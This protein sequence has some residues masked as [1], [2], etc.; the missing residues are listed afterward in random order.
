VRSISRT[1]AEMVRE[2]FQATRQRRLAVHPRVHRSWTFAGLRAFSNCLLRDLNTAVVS[3]E[4]M[5]GARSI[6]VDYV[7]YDEIGH[8]A[9]AT[10]IESLASLGGLDQVVA[11]LEKVA[12]RA[13]RTYHLVLLSDHGQS[14]GEPFA[15]RYGIDLSDLCRSLTD[16]QTTGIEGSIEGW[17]RVDSVLEDLGGTRTA[18]VQQAASRR[19]DKW[20]GPPSSTSTALSTSTRWT[21]RPSNPS[22]DAM[23]VSVG[24]RT[25]ASCWH[26]HTCSPRP[27]RSWAATSCTSTSCA[28][29]RTWGTGLNCRGAPRE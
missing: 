15:A 18:G 11:I 13:P 26:H 1:I 27:S 20:T 24:G 3:E 7:D 23:V 17:G 6:Y 2:R 8:H 14:Q 16:S 4:M 22:W 29:S 10:R 5:R 25:A 28:C 12:Q 21:W 9:G 19:V